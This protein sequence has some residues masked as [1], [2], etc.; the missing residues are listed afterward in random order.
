LCREH[1][2]RLNVSHEDFLSA[3]WKPRQQQNAQIPKLGEVLPRDVYAARTGQGLALYCWMSDQERRLLEDDPG[4]MDVLTE[5][6][7]TL[8]L[9]GIESEFQDV[10]NERS[11]AL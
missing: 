11:C 8:D 9:V 7:R 10:D 3:L 1:P 5:W 6:L 4:N 2:V